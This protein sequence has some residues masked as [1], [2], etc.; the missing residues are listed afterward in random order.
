[1]SRREADQTGTVEGIEKELDR[2][3]TPQSPDLSDSELDWEE[4]SN[5]GESSNP[6]EFLDTE[7][8]LLQELQDIENTTGLHSIAYLDT[9]D[10]LGAL[11]KSQGRYEIAEKT[12]LRSKGRFAH[13]VNPEEFRNL[14]AQRPNTGSVQ[15]KVGRKTPLT[16][17]RDRGYG[18]AWGDL[19]Y[20]VN[21]HRSNS[22]RSHMRH[23]CHA[24]MKQHNEPLF[25]PI[26]VRHAWTC[27]GRGL[28]ND[29]HAYM[30]WN[31][32][33]RSLAW[34]VSLRQIGMSFY[35]QSES[36]TRRFVCWSNCGP[37][38]I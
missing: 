26:A 35:P 27:N 6:K 24:I 36:S 1:M 7:H 33:F 23:A 34:R 37:E 11:Y 22:D 20:P 8:S 2:D 13:F 25:N 32:E 14:G 31:S 30:S 38:K 5:W 9:L 19:N 16:D 28:K 21:M 29:L 10:R 17:A 4:S 12:F 18:W 3:V 15:C